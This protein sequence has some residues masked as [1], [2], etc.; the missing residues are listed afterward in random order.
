MVC[1]VVL[2]QAHIKVHRFSFVVI[3][4]GEVGVGLLAFGLSR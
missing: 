4:Q 2:G 3:L 1:L